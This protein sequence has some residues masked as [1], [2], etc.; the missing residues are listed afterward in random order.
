MKVVVA[1]PAATFGP[2]QERG[3]LIPN[4]ILS[5]LEKKDFKMNKGEQRRDLIFVGDLV[6]GLLLSG[7]NDKAVGE[8]INLGSNRGFKIKDVA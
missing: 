7:M 2:R 3:M 8:I 6:D 5:A 1:R 4:L